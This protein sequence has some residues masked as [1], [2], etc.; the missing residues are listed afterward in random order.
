MKG[1]ETVKVTVKLPKAI[2]DFLKDTERAVEKYIEDN[3]VGCVMSDLEFE[4]SHIPKVE[5]VIRKYGLKPVF[6]EF[7]VLPSYYEKRG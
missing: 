3:V 1:E 2:V 4:F 5:E 6:K 7:G